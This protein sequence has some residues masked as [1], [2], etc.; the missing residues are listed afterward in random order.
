MPFSRLSIDSLRSIRKSSTWRSQMPFFGK[1]WT[2]K[3]LILTRSTSGIARV[4]GLDQD[5]VLVAGA[6]QE[7]D[8]V[9]PV[10]L[11]DQL[12]ALGDPH[13]R[14]VAVRLDVVAGHHP[15][16]VAG[17]GGVDR[18]LDRV[19][20]VDDKRRRPSPHGSHAQ[21][22]PQGQKSGNARAS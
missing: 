11:G 20:G 3:P 13:R 15:H 1:P 2:V 9:D 16:R 5:A 18:R 6:G 21:G 7:A 19:A 10:A 8:L 14:G 22:Q 12:E 4:G 17:L